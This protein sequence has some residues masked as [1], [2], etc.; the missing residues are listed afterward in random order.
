MRCWSRGCDRLEHFAVDWRASTAARRL[1]LIRVNYRTATCRSMRV[2]AAGLAG[3]TCGRAVRSVMATPAAKARADSILRSSVLLSDAAA[4]VAISRSRDRAGRHALRRAG[5]CEPAHA[6]GGGIL[7]RSRRSAA[8]GRERLMPKPGTSHTACRAVGN[9]PSV[10]GAPHRREPRRVVA[11]AACSPGTGR[12]RRPHDHLV[13]QAENGASRRRI[14]ASSTSVDLAEPAHSAA[15][16]S[17]T[18]GA[19]R[20]SAKT[21]TRPGADPQAS[22]WL[23]IP[24]RLLNGPARVTDIDGLTSSKR[25]SALACWTASRASIKRRPHWWSVAR[26]HRRPARPD[27]G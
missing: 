24:D 1:E 10:E 4:L 25:R 9:R 8:C 16:R 13:A 22:Q 7:G 18:P 12:G 3:A 6:R 26:A 2:G 14:L 17:A 19:I 11:A 15:C 23:P 20:S 21:R 5:C 27:R